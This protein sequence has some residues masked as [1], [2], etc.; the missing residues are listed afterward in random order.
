MAGIMLLYH[1]FGLI[2]MKKFLKIFLIAV[3]LLSVAG[4]VVY[5]SL[6]RMED[7]EDLKEGCSRYPSRPSRL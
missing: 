7:M 6:A 4:I 1:C 3:A 5:L 2:G